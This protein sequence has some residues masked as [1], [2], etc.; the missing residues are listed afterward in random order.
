MSAM[1]AVFV[2]ILAEQMAVERRLEILDRR[3]VSGYPLTVGSHGDNAVVVC[4]TGTTEER[5]YGAAAAVLEEF[6]LG[7]VLSARL[8]CS[9]GDTTRVGDLVICD[10]SY[11]RR[12]D[13]PVSEPP[14]EADQRL[15]ALGEQAARSAKLRYT[16]G[17]SLTADFRHLRFRDHE[18]V[19]RDLDVTVVD[20]NGHFLAEAARERE[21]PFLSVRVAMGRSIEGPPTSLGITAERGVLRP[22]GVLAYCLRRPTRIA[23]FVRLANNVRR[24]HRRLAAFAREFL[25]EWSL[26]P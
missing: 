2:S 9:I 3:T 8:A 17:S 23:G 13:S 14:E 26:E 16:M 10:K 5:S 20:G 4:R 21:I 15:L 1:L 7:G 18:P 12:G 25:R 11:V 22:G 6:S 24:G 19:G